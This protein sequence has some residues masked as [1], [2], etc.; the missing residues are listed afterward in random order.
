MQE[1]ARLKLGRL[2]WTHGLR[3]LL[4]HLDPEDAHNAINRL[5]IMGEKRP[6]FL[7]AARWLWHSPYADV[8]PVM[9]CGQ[10]WRHCVG[11]GPGIDKNGEQIPFWN[12][13]AGSEEIGGVCPRPQDGRVRPR[14][15][16]VHRLTDR[17]WITFLVNQMGYP[18]HG[19]L[20]V[21]NR[22]RDVFRQNPDTIPIIVQMAPNAATVEKYRASG[23]PDIMLQDYLDVAHCFLPILRPGKDYLSV[24][25][26]P[27]TPGL[28]EFFARHYEE[29]ASKLHEGIVRLSQTYVP[30][31]LYKMPTFEELGITE[32]EFETMIVV[33]A[34]YANG[35][36]GTNTLT[37]EEAKQA[38]GISIGGG[39]SGPP[40]FPFAL[41]TQR[42]IA[43]II[44]KHNLS[45]D[46][47][48]LGGI[49][50]PQC[51]RT[52]GRNHPAAIQLVSWVIDQGPA[53]VHAALEALGTH[54]FERF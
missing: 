23:D 6:E 30:P 37:S 26:S 24:G 5:V 19:A 18:S 21:S 16:L 2:V 49:T 17:G 53:A 40:L 3:P 32:A 11:I 22:L 9:V 14:V 51:V 43:K 13:I 45:L 25:I 54:W 1:M 42:M 33:L 8:H 10:E 46:L 47:V 38:F 4:M 31:L 15:F 20:V 29:F 44:A 41:H 50:T 36:A 39:V 12:E 34:K 7:R 48:A 35:I 52:V 27:N 28:Y